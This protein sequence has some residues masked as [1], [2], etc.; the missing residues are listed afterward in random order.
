MP[1]T[2]EQRQERRRFIGSSDSP[3]ILGVNPPG[4]G[5]A[6]DVYASKVFDIAERGDAREAMELG[7]EFETPLVRWA[8]RQLGA[9]I[10]ENVRTERGLF[11]ANHDAILRTL[12]GREGIEAKVRTYD[13]SE[14]GEEGTDQIPPRVI[15]QAQHQMYT[16][17]L[18]RVHVPVML[19]WHGRL[20]R[21]LYRVERSEK[22]IA[23]IVEAGE[24]FWEDHVLRRRPPEGVTGDVELFKRIV[25][26]P[27]LVAQ[28]PA[29]LVLEWEAAKQLAGQAKKDVEQRFAA[30][31]A[32]VGEADAWEWGDPDGLYYTYFEYEAHDLDERRLKVEEPELVSRYLKPR[33]YRTPYR[34][35]PKT[36]G[37]K[38][39]RAA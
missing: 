13:P 35:N 38:G 31:L 17:N 28:V 7:N 14:F 23:A 26:Q 20:S 2:P 4:Y 30:L 33:K 6:L 9:P 32:R 18:P 34:R 25:R 3:A 21:R 36:P 12:L 29:E 24:R 5:T 39:R 1:I 10:E 16:G 19:P 11:A 8:G 15:V 37:R 27:G 22:I